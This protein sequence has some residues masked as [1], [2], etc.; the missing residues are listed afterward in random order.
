MA[1]SLLKKMLPSRTAISE[2]ED[3]GASMTA[4]A[5]AAEQTA[6]CEK[7]EEHRGVTDRNEGSTSATAPGPAA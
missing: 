6:G 5:E 2:N 3:P 4:H 1:L 7:D